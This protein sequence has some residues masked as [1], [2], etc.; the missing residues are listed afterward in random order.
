MKNTIS[1][2]FGITKKEYLSYFS[3]PIAYI[4]ITTFLVAVNWIFFRS[5][6]LVGQADMRQ[7]F[8]IAPWIFLFFIPAVSMGKW[9]EEKKQGTLEI[10]FT[11]PI[12]DRTIVIAKFLASLALVI[13]AILLTFPI[14]A[15][16][17][18]V[19]DPDWGQI[20]A[21]YFGMTML[22]AAYLSVGLAISASTKNQ[23][24]AFILT[25]AANFLILVLG[26]PLIL[27][28]RGG[29]VMSAISYLSFIPHYDSIARGV[30]DISDIVYYCSVIA[31]F[32]FI[33]LKILDR[34]ART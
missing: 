23:I 13:T 26:T 7:F 1:N 9:S 14:A 19:G 16:V 18:I 33:N 24:V 25:V 30:I 6:F 3:S 5:F 31:F 10:L 11:L 27:G 2:T 28:G 15:T 12:V 21:G 32:L 29:L 8:G 34:K 4:Y 17:S 22:G 20:V